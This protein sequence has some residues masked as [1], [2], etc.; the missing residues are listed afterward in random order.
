LSPRAPIVIMFGALFCTLAV[1]FFQACHEGKVAEYFYW[2]LPDLSCLLLAAL[3]IAMI[4]FRWHRKSVLRIATFFALV[5]CTWSVIH[6]GYLIRTGT[7]ALPRVLVPVVRDPANALRMIGVNLIKMPL[8]A[9]LLL[10]P[11][12]VGLGFVFCVLAKPRLR[13]YNRRAFTIRIAVCL[14]VGISAT[15]ARPFVGHGGMAHAHSPHVRAVVS[16]FRPPLEESKRQLPHF[17]EVQLGLKRNRTGHNVVIVILEGVQYAYTSLADSRNTLTPYLAGLAKAGVEFT[18][19]R[20]SVTHTT[21]ALFSLLTGRFPSAS[22]DL[23]ETVP[24]AKPYASLATILQRQLGFRTAFF[25]SARGDFESRPGLIYNLGF[26]KFWARDDLDDPNSF[27]AYLACDEFAMLEPIM[28][29]VKEDSAP[30]LLTILCS[31]THDPYEVPPWYGEPAKEPTDRYRQTISYTDQFLAALDAELA[32]LG[33][34]DRT[35]LCVVGDHG[36]AFGE[37][38]LSG[39]DGVAFDEVLR[40]PFCIRAPVLGERGRRVVDPVSSIDVTPTLLGL[41]GFKLGG[42]GFDGIDCLGAIPADRQVYFSGWLRPAPAG[43]VRGDRKFI[44]YVEDEMAFSYDLGKDPGELVR[45]EVP[46]SQAQEIGDDVTAWQ[47]HTI[48]RLGRRQPG[49]KVLFGRWLVRWSNRLFVR[50][51]LQDE[52]EN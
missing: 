38:G 44:Y 29:W 23:A 8:A 17:D 2:V 51:K 32:G 26:E 49:T 1:K 5:V 3:I 50:T 14:V 11:S 4:C 28:E 24:V 20:S 6:A 52:D 7:D 46:E 15:L 22:D 16:L 37:H 35:I 21:K 18:N 48:F 39:H 30:F 13:A 42:A 41:L 19:T 10:G 9:T 31:V 47:K 45:M 33:L 43:F 25:Q 36:E 12:A 34:A 27:I 40:V